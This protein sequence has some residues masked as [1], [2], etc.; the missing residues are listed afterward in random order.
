MSDRR[1]LFTWSGLPWWENH[2]VVFDHNERRIYVYSIVS[3][4]GWSMPFNW[5]SRP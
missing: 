2:R 3:R 5:E 1:N 4:L